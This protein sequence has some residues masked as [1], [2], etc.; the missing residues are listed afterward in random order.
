MRVVVDNFPVSPR[1]CLFYNSQED[2]CTL[3]DAP[4]QLDTSVYNY[5]YFCDYLVSYS[6]LY[7]EQTTLDKLSNG[8]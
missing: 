8:Y 1:E 7:Y 3:V 6:E 2:I 5:N 4:C